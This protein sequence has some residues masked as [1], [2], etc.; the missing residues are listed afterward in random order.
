MLSKI[1]YAVLAVPAVILAAANVA[2]AQSAFDP[3]D[4]TTSMA[5]DAASTM[6]PI[7]LALGAAVVGLAI[8]A[9]GVRAVLGTI[10][11]GGKNVGG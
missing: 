3:A 10:R 2:G 7:I 6:G 1:K 8:A 11:K 9:W 4:A 5:T